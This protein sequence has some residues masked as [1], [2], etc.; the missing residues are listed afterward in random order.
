MYVCTT[1]VYVQVIIKTLFISHKSRYS[2]SGPDHWR[3]TREAETCAGFNRIE[4]QVKRE[5]RCRFQPKRYI[6][7]RRFRLVFTQFYF[8][9]VQTKVDPLHFEFAPG[10]LDARTYVLIDTVS[11]PEGKS[12]TAMSAS[13]A[14]LLMATCGVRAGC[15]AVAWR[16]RACALYTG[17]RRTSR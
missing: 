15:V 6:G 12:L 5:T 14:V 2:A 4:P 16:R 9:G 17:A 10:T 1:T 13:R 8:G 11:R 7:F 3:K